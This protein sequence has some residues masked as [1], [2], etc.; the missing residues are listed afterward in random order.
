[1]LSL[2]WHNCLKNLIFWNLGETCPVSAPATPV[3]LHQVQV[4][5]S[6]AVNIL[7]LAQW[8]AIQTEG[9][10][11]ASLRRQ[12]NTGMGSELPLAILICRL[13]EPEVPP[14]PLI[15]LV[16]LGPLS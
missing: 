12:L 3:Q 7:S 11:L 4:T 10:E 15:W 8:I 16:C 6:P 13:A 9:S 1:M 2:D 5:P 14:P